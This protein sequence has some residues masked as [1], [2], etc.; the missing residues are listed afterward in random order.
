MKITV[1]M[2]P[3][4]GKVTCTPG[5]TMSALEKVK[6]L[7]GRH[8]MVDKVM[9]FE[10]TDDNIS[11][12][13]SAMRGADF[14]GLQAKSKNLVEGPRGNFKTTYPPTQLQVE[15]FGLSRGKPLF[16][17]FEK[18]GAGKTKIVLD[19]AV[20]LWFQ[21]KIDG[22]FI[23]SYAGVHEQWVLDE[24][25]KHVAK[26]ANLLA[27]AW[28]SGKRLDD[29]ILAPDPNRFR[30]FAMNYE[31]YATSDKAFA[32]AKRFAESGAMAAAA[33]ECHRLKSDGSVVSERAI[34]HRDDWVARAI[35]SGEP[36]PLGVQDYYAQ[37][38]FLD[39]KIIGC[40]TYEGFKSM[41]CRVS[42]DISRKVIGYVN[43]EHLH[44]LMA[45]YVHVGAPD[46]EAKQIFEFSR[47]NLNS[48][49]REAYDQLSTDLMIDLEGADENDWIEYRLKGPLAKLTKLREIASG[50][51]TDREGKVHQLDTGRL[52]LM[53]TLLDIKKGHK[54]IIW[55]V[56]KEDH[57]LQ[58]AALGDM[59]AVYN[60]DT[61]K[62][63]RREI[64]KEF[65][66]PTSR[67]K[68]LLGSKA[69]M[70]TG[71]NLQGSA[72]WNLYYNDNN[73]AGQRW[74]A[75][76]RLYRLGVDKDVLYT[77][78]LARATVDVGTWNSNRRKRDVA[79]MSLNEFKALLTETD[80]DESL[81]LLD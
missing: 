13:R 38:C 26:E 16:A 6:A 35:A 46:I 32:A 39:P 49:A 41:F 45:P 5:W 57:R 27:T 53:Q 60:G 80:I 21:G 76:R 67:L 63:Q 30:L 19:W 79:D 52:E 78:I 75:D 70:G 66:D 73:N 3:P 59:A 72:Y 10:L 9:H 4:R 58:A 1:D 61:P 15:A 65:L 42:N 44:R 64:I 68:Y 22:L 74:Q 33:D 40:W 24:A 43:Q 69:A 11:Y 51:L 77:D 12:L 54:A 20:D 29:T 47:F 48:K 14:I 71:L 25:P 23:L 56:F 36:T 8:R 31:A 2:R 37:F 81:L 18:P 17:F 62:N 50:R 28:R 55:S 34:G 7:P